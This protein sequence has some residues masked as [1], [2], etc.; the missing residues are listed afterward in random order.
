MTHGSGDLNYEDCEAL[1]RAARAEE[2]PAAA[3]RR[4]V[5]LAVMASVAA[6]VQLASVGSASAAWSTATTGALAPQV[7]GVTS[8]LGGAKGLIHL[9]AGGKFLTGL[10]VGAVAG[11]ALSAAAFVAIPPSPTASKISTPLATTARDER[12]SVPQEGRARATDFRPEFPS[13]VHGAIDRGA[14]LES[15]PRPLTEAKPLGESTPYARALPVRPLAAN[16]PSQLATGAGTPDRLLEETRALARVQEALSRNAPEEALALLQ[17][18]ERK[19]PAGQLVQER[20]AARVLATCASGNAAEASKARSQF[21]SAYPDS[22]LI[23]RVLQ[24]CT[25]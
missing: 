1:Y 17:T 3:D 19:Y 23:R 10:L 8:A 15:V 18:Q 5:R 20:A 21:L 7:G 9:L 12:P 16:E 13:K 14:T 4:A 25:P 22:P 6:T 2:Q 11:T 24:G